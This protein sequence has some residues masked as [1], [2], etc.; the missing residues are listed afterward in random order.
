VPEIYPPLILTASIL[1][2]VFLYRFKIS[3]KHSLNFNNTI[4]LSY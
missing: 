1:F 3:V 4:I 2:A